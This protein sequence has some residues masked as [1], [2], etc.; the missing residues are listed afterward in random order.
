MQVSID[1][2][3]TWMP[4]FVG[5]VPTMESE[6]AVF[7]AGAMEFDRDVDWA[8]S[9]FETATAELVGSC[10]LHPRDDG[11]VLEIGYW[12]RS[13]R[14]GRGYATVAARCLTAAAFRFVPSAQRVV[15]RMDRANVASARVPAKLGYVLD[16]EE[17]RERL[18]PG[19]TGRGLVWSMS[20]PNRLLPDSDRRDR[21]AD[22][23]GAPRPSRLT[24]D[25]WRSR[26]R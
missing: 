24:A 13:D 1:A 4:W 9:M 15:I 10:A 6:R 12:V 14:R 11:S 8:Y 20:R 26:I 17:P 23:P 5:G 21:G 25:D 7:E 19:H 2:L 16:G 18:A 3:S 22:R